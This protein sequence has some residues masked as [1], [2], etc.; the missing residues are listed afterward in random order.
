[1]ITMYKIKSHY[2][3]QENRTKE[4]SI[5]E[6]EV[7]RVTDSSVW[8]NGRRR[9]KT[10]SVWGLS[11]SSFALEETYFNTYDEAKEALLHF[12]RVQQQKAQQ[13]ADQ[14]AASLEHAE[15]NL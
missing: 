1:M 7:E 6:V 13:L 12:L 3:T 14:M 15:N 5:N 2:S 4:F 10:T 8:I 9:K 11:T